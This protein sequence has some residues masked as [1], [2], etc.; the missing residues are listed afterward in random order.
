MYIRVYMYGNQTSVFFFKKSNKRT[1]IQKIFLKI[2]QNQCF[3]ETFYL[4]NFIFHNI[5]SF[6][7]PWI[8]Y[9]EKWKVGN[10]VCIIVAFSS[11]FYT[12]TFHLWYFSV[13]HVQ[14]VSKHDTVQT[15][16]LSE[17]EWEKKPLSEYVRRISQLMWLWI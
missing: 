10:Y 3:I 9:F 11:H 13:M 15:V 17:K 4:I 6:R 1:L 14:C 2:E 12:G 7:V 8:L 16:L 5:I